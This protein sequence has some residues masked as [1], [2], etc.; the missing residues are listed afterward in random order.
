MEKLHKA[1]YPTCTRLAASSFLDIH[2]EPDWLLI[3]S[4]QNA[5][6]D[7]QEGILYDTPHISD[8]ELR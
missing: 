8:H 6:T 4:K 7:Y 1:H 2:I 5:T 3:Y